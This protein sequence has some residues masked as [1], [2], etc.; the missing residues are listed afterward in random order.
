M[1]EDELA[2]AKVQLKSELV[3]RGESSS[4]RM[5]SLAR[6]W[7]FERKLTTIHEIKEAIDAVTR[8]QIANLLRRYPATDRLTIAAIGPLAEGD[9]IGDAL[10]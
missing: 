3:M 10:G 2:R 9:L 5:A 6:S 8:E 7:W 1:T 4:A